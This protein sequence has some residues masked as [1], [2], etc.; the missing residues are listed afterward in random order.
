MKIND[1]V[2]PCL[3]SFTLKCNVHVMGASFDGDKLLK[4]IRR[5]SPNA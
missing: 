4:L 2:Y 1:N 3:C 5:C